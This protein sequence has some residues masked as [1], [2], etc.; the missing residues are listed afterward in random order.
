MPKPSAILRGENWVANASK[1]ENKC[2]QSS[3]FYTVEY[4]ESIQHSELHPKYTGMRH[5]GS[6]IDI[7]GIKKL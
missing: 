3:A 6:W 2:S 4:S 5:C 1:V 7:Q